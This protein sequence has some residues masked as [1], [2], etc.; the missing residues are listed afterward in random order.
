[1]RIANTGRA[2]RA[3]GTRLAPTE[4]ERR[5]AG[6]PKAQSNPWLLYVAAPAPF[7]KYLQHMLTW[8]I[9][10]RQNRMLP[11]ILPKDR[12]LREDR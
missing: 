1:M 6:A 7:A 4:A 2:L 12:R 10:F 11:H 8:V 3:S 9:I 5:L